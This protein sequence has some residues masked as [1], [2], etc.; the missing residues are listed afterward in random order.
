MVLIAYY[1][2][3]RPALL[4]RN[5]DALISLD[6]IV[7]EIGINSVNIDVNLSLRGDETETS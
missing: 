7:D 3:L 4:Q 6:I 2:I 5:D 1:P